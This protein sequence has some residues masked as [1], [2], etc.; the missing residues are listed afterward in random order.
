MKKVT[1]GI[2]LIL[3]SFSFNIFAAGGGAVGTVHEV[4][5]ISNANGWGTEYNGAFW[6]TVTGVTSA[7]ACPVVNGLVRF[8]IPAEDEM[9][10]VTALSA[11]LS[12]AT[13][14]IDW[15]DTILYAN[16]CRPRDVYVTQ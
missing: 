6:V 13:I 3:S 12:G 2:F 11:K 16:E 14:G 5:A 8:M 1:F 7:G 15:D 9:L 10:Y 4:A